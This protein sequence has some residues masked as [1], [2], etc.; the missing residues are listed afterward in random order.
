MVGYCKYFCQSDQ[1]IC[2]I[3]C[4]LLVGASRS[5]VGALH[6][7]VPSGYGSG[8]FCILSGKY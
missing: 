1:L 4:K 8:L 2:L 7:I 3:F 5:V 6:L